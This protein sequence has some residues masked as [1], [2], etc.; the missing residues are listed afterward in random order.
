MAALSP[1]SRIGL[2][3]YGAI[4]RAVANALHERRPALA[5]ALLTR[6]EVTALPS[7]VARVAGVAELVR[8]DVSL[9]VEAAGHAALASL[10]PPVLE[11]GIDVIAVSAGSLL[12]RQDGATLAQYLTRTARQSGANLTVPGGAIGGLDYV[13]AVADQP[14]LA[15]TYTSRKPPAAWLDE[16]ARRRMSPADVTEP[17]V[18]F[19]GAVEDAARLYPQNLNVAATLALACGDPERVTVRVLI[20]PAVSANTHEIAIDSA[21]GRARFEFAN[22]PSPTNPKTSA[23]TA[24]S[25]L[26]AIEEHL[27]RHGPAR[28]TTTSNT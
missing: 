7:N 2:I 28:H 24:L 19:D 27:D 17:I 16:L 22:A 15:V 21:A 23:V 6:S 26:R 4:G 25:V 9:V 20:D 11:A 12:S 8:A 1:H 5:I 18:L 10:V 14:G 13:R 3:G